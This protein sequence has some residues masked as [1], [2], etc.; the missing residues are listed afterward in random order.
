MCLQTADKPNLEHFDPDSDFWPNCGSLVL[1]V[2]QSTLHIGSDQSEKPKAL[3]QSE[4]SKTLDQSEKSNG[5]DQSQMPKYLEQSTL[6]EFP[7]QMGQVLKST[8]KGFCPK[9]SS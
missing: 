3:D 2:V 6:S 1:T 5:L 8:I 7:N 9:T 4:K